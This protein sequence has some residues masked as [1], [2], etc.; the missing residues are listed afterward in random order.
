M[1]ANISILWNPL[2]SLW[3]I[4]GVVKCNQVQ[5][6]HLDTLVEGAASDQVDAFIHLVHSKL[7]LWTHEIGYF[8]RSSRAAHYS[9]ACVRP[10]ST[11]TRRL[12]TDWPPHQL[13]PDCVQRQLYAARKL[14]SPNSHEALPCRAALCCAVTLRRD[15]LCYGAAPRCAVAL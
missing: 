7:P 13:T 11:V 2:F 9:T 8:R 4:A 6:K 1:L 15:V 14:E 5:S 3:L 10:K 12:R